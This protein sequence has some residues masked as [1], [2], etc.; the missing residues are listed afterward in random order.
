M[1]RPDFVDVTMEGR[2]RNSQLAVAKVNVDRIPIIRPQV[3]APQINYFVD[4]VVL[5]FSQC[6]GLKQSHTIVC[7]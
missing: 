5:G 4:N 7:R 6:H 1:A 3:D 2:K